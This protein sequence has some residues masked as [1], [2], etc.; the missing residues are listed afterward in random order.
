METAATLLETRA[1]RKTSE[2]AKQRIAKSDIDS[3]VEMSCTLIR[4]EPK[5]DN[6]GECCLYSSAT[7]L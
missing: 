3:D 6:V 5:N 1:A 7:I 4:K 2:V